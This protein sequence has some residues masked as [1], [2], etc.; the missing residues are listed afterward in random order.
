[1]QQEKGVV[2]D[3]NLSRHGKASDIRQVR[4]IKHLPI[5][6]TSCGSELPEA[7]ARTRLNALGNRVVMIASNANRFVLTQPI[8]ALERSRSVINR[9]PNEE[10]RIKLFVDG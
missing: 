6:G 8:E 1:M 4:V 9:V 2:A 3:G 5:H 10:A 7:R